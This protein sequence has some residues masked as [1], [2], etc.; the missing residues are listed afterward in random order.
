MSLKWLVMALLP[1]E[2][3][4]SGEPFLVDMILIRTVGMDEKTLNHI[5]FCLSAVL[6]LCLSIVTK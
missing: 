4:V 5:H 6:S 1:R 3:S 2:S